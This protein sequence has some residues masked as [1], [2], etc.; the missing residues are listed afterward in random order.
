MGYKNIG[1]HTRLVDTDVKVK[2]GCF[3]GSLDG[4]TV[5]RLVTSHF[6]VEVSNSGHPYFVDKQGRRV[7]LYLSVDAR[8]TPQGMAALKAWH[9]EQEQAA[10]KEAELFSQQQAELQAAMAGLSHE[11]VMRRL[12]QG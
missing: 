4:E 12:A 5:N 11:E 8:N 10:K 9:R 7:R 1:Y 3:G 2:G 6:K